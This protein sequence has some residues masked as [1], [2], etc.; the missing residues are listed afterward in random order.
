VHQRHDEALNGRLE[1]GGE[2]G[3]NA[4]DDLVITVGIG[5][6]DVRGEREKK[7]YKL[8]EKRKKKN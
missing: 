5:V 6:S 2:R 1:L 3:Q 8:S 7:D 4:L